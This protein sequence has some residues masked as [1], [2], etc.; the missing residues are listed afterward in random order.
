MLW[1]L[2][3]AGYADPLLVQRMDGSKLLPRAAG[4]GSGGGLDLRELGGDVHYWWRDMSHALRGTLAGL[5][6][7][8]RIL[9]LAG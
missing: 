9:G 7:A 2:V 5:V 4:V 6:L 8:P 3:F 1:R